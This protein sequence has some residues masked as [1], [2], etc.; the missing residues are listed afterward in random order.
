MTHTS[1]SN[2]ENSNISYSHDTTKNDESQSKNYDNDSLFNRLFIPIRINEAIGGQA[3]NYYRY[4]EKKDCSKQWNNVKWCL[5]MKSK[6]L[7]ERKKMILE[8]E[9]EKE[10][11]YTKTKSSLDVWELRD[12]PLTEI[13][14]LSDEVND[15]V[16]EESK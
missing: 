3:A 13:F 6:S 9:T 5:R 10:E 2:S 7:E 11:K 14:P 8:R 15:G 16:D 12:T 4:G 1:S